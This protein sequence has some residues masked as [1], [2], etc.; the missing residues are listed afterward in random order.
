M[1]YS[2]GGW[3]GV[4][5][6]ALPYVVGST[7]RTLGVS[8]RMNELFFSEATRQSRASHEF[9]MNQADYPEV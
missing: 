3:C 7:A 4:H 8:E 5:I 2:H 6:G 1:S 9:F